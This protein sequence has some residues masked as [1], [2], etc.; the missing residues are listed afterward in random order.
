MQ[1]GLGATNAVA[2]RDADARGAGVG[3][4]ADNRLDADRSRPIKRRSRCLLAGG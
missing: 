3:W 1:T 2:P 4:L